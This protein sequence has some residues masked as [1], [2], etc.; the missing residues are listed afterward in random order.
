[1]RVDTEEE[2]L[3]HLRPD[4]DVILSDY[5]MPQLSAPRALSLLQELGYDNP[6]I[7]LTGTVSE[8]V[9]VEKHKTRERQIIY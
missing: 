1:V 5:S 9:A 3:T 7:M 8:D 6:V 4:L 2:Y